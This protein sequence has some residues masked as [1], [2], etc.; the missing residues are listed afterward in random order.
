M[1]NWRETKKM[2]NRKIKKENKDL[3]NNKVKNLRKERKE[4]RRYD[5]QGNI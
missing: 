3:V 1:R 2:Q 4:K 5:L